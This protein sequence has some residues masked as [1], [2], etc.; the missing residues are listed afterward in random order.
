MTQ[1]DLTS[2]HEA[3]NLYEDETEKGAIGIEVSNGKLYVTKEIPKPTKEGN[4]DDE[5]KGAG[6]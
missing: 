5:K 1:E 2:L 3:I 4:K 6:K